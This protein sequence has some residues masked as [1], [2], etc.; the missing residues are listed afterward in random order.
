[1]TFET[2]TGGAVFSVGSITWPSSVMVSEAVS[3]IT[4]NVLRRFLTGS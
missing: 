1:V 3:R 4:S 2:P